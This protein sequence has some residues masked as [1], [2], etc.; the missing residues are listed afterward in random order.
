[1][2]LENSL[3]DMQ[4][5]W[6]LQQSPLHLPKDL[7]S[8]AHA[9]LVFAAPLGNSV[10]PPAKRCWPNVKSKR[11]WRKGYYTF[12]VRVVSEKRNIMLK[13]GGGQRESKAGCCVWQ[14][15]LGNWLHLTNEYRK[16]LKNTTE[17]CF[18]APKMQQKCQRK[19]K[20][21]FNFNGIEI[22]GKTQTNSHRH[23]VFCNVFNGLLQRKGFL[24]GLNGLPAWQSQAC[25]FTRVRYSFAVFFIWFCSFFLCE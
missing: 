24:F 23:A 11:R 10:H 9:D 20:N 2:L 3:W 7:F 13:T 14:A 18:L 5:A 21:D 25:L 16:S 15:S 4:P 19:R 12:S 8:L 17:S 1:M 22:R 6:R